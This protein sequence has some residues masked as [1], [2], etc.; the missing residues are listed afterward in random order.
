MSHT[1]LAMC[2]S[3]PASFRPLGGSGSFRRQQP[4]H[5]AQLGHDS[6]PHAQGHPPRGAE[7]VDQAPEFCNPVGCVNKTAGPPARSSWSPIAVISS[8]RRHRIGR[9]FAARPSLSSWARKSRRSRYFILKYVIR[10]LIFLTG[11]EPVPRIR[12]D[13]NLKFRVNPCQRCWDRAAARADPWQGDRS[14]PFEAC[15][16]AFI[17]VITVAPTG[18]T[19]RPGAAGLRRGVT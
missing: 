8:L 17:A 15:A 18:C 11:Y 19:G 10:D 12:P 6:A 2:S 7:Q 1:A 5:V 9:V 3:L 4:A 14:S 16:P 13:L